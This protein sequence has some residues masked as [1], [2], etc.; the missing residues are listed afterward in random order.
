[1]SIEIKQGRLYRSNDGEYVYNVFSY[2]KGDPTMVLDIHN[3]NLESIITKP[4]YSVEQ[5]QNQLNIGTIV[6]FQDNEIIGKLDE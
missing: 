4:R 6:E 1:M 3:K 5:F 2:Q